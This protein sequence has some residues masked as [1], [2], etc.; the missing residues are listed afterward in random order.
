[1]IS[2]HG[3]TAAAIADILPSSGKL[4]VVSVASV[5]FPLPPS[6]TPSQYSTIG[7]LTLCFHLLFVFCAW[8]SPQRLL[9]LLPYCCH[10]DVMLAEVFGSI[11]MMYDMQSSAVVVYQWRN[12][13]LEAGEVCLLSGGP[14]P[15]LTHL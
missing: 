5:D 7:S 11:G 15:I 2:C 12:C 4:P 9:S 10:L 1:M 14:Q 3:S 13:S 6:A 8:I